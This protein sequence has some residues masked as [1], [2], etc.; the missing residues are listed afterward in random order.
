MKFLFSFILVFILSLNAVAAEDANKDQ[1]DR[2]KVAMTI[3]TK[4]CFMTLNQEERIAFLDSKF[5]RHEDE[6]KKLFLDMF[7]AKEGEV[8][9]A[10][11]PKAAYAI[12][13]ENNGNCHLLAQKADD[14]TIHEKIKE[15]SIQT[16]KSLVGMEVKYN[17][18]QKTVLDSSGFEVRGK[19]GKNIMIVVAST[20]KNPP[21]EKPAAFITLAVRPK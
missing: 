14:V 21:E 13:V 11:F 1:V 10:V 12:I 19:D 20:A 7:K 8:W 15:L 4:A 5:S 16:R 2:A 3:F 9:T 6:Q 18:I 17:D